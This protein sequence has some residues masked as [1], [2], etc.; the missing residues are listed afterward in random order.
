[1]LDLLLHELFKLQSRYVLL[2]ILWTFSVIWLVVSAN[3]SQH[4]HIAHIKGLVLLVGVRRLCQMLSE[5]L[6]LCNH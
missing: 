5:V 3:I 6:D 2:M 1:M 4:S